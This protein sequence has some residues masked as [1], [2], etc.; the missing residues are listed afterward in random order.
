MLEDIDLYK[1][2]ILGFKRDLARRD[3]LITELQHSPERTAATRLAEELRQHKATANAVVAKRDREIARLENV[4]AG[5]KMSISMN[6]RVEEAVGD[7]VVRD[8]WG[9]V[10]YDVMNWCLSNGAVKGGLMDGEVVREVVP[11]WERLVGEGHRVHVVQAVLATGLVKEV[12]RGWFL[13][14]GEEE[15]RVLREVE[16]RC[17]ETGGLVS[18][19]GVRWLTVV[20]TPTALT[21]WRSSTRALL[22]T[23]LLVSPLLATLT[24]SI[25]ATLLALTAPFLPP[26]TPSR[27]KS[28]TA[29]VDATIRIVS[30]MRVQRADFRAV[31]ETG[32][33]WNPDCMEDLTGEEEDG[34]RVAC[35]AWPGVEKW[36]D[37]MGEGRDVENCVVKAR[38]VCLRDEEEEE[39][40]VL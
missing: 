14:L 16:E 32:G 33:R 27:E 1:L 38:V 40:E 8:S 2:D 18:W 9:R 22:R 37:E 3:T 26:P 5:L 11:E 15:D 6:T 21:N 17:K 4:V 30:L 28:L 29:I 19:F 7:S 23:Q 20:A 24:S 34:A 25:T 10:G 13:G 31:M 36:G 35:V 39:E 12:F